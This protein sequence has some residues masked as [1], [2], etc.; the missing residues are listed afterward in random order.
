MGREI[1]EGVKDKKDDGRSLSCRCRGGQSQVPG[2]HV[3]DKGRLPRPLGNF[4]SV[5]CA[6]DTRVVQDPLVG[7]P[8]AMA[9]ARARA[10]ARGCLVPCKQA[11]GSASGA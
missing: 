9:M 5:Q 3:P 1:I 6:W 11:P 7:R 10:R 2:T 8:H 4:S